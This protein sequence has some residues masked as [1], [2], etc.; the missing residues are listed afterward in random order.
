MKF[1]D[2]YY[3]AALMNA[4]AEALSS[5]PASS[6]DAF[7][8]ELDEDDGEDLGSYN[9]CLEEIDRYRRMDEWIP[10]YHNILSTTALNCKRQL[11]KSGA[12]SFRPVDFL[13]YTSERSS[14]YLRVSAFHDL[15]ELGMIHNGAI[16][17]WFLFVLGMDPSPYIR[18]C[19]L[20]LFGKAIG[21]LAIGESSIAAASVIAQQ[22]GLII[23]Q[24]SSTEARQA[25]L[26]RRQ[27]V[28]GA[29]NALKAEIGVNEVLKKGLWNAITSPILTLREIGELLCI[30]E[31]LYTPE[32]S[33]IVV[34]KYPRYWR[35]TKVG[36]VRF[37]FLFLE[38]IN[39]CL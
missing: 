2:C 35:C 30:C 20:R 9:A 4:L 38:F 11:I 33:M 14:D 13:Q 31:L 36:K 19:M 6:S 17:R 39:T 7:D 18:D 1:S 34:L 22:D 26:A 21:A 27:T 3:I 8:M 10:S 28:E 32:S 25:V 16:L 5:K 37:S 29:L 23:E 12:V 15:V 24:E